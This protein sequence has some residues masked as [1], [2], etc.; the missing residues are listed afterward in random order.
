MILKLPIDGL[1]SSFVSYV[2]LYLRTQNF[3]FHCQLSSL[4]GIWSIWY[5][6]RSFLDILHTIVECKI[7]TT[8][9]SNDNI[10][11]TILNQNTVCEFILH[12]ELPPHCGKHCKNLELQEKL[13][14][15]SYRFFNPF[16]P[17]GSPFD[18]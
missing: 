16:T 15:K 13:F 4:R 9:T 1:N 5:E 12:V 6:Q 2:I 3:E 10:T 17:T 14:P 18:E 11:K 8:I 7:T